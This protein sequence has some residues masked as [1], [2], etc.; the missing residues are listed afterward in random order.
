MLRIGE[1]V[2]LD[3]TTG[4][5]R[6]AS[7][8]RRRAVRTICVVVVGLLC[9]A[10]GGR[11]DARSSARSSMDPVV[12][13]IVEPGGFNVLHED[14][15]LKEGQERRLPRGMPR[16]VAVELSTGSWNQQKADLERG[17]LGHLEPGTL[18]SIT[19][20]RIIGIRISDAGN[21]TNILDNANHGTGTA[22]AA[23]GLVAGTDP[24][25]LL[26]LVPDTSKQSWEWLAAQDWIDIVSASYATLLSDDGCPSYA[27]VKKIASQGRLV[28]AAVGNGEQVGQFFDPSGVPEAYQ[29]GGVDGDGHTYLDPTGQTNPAATPNRPYETGDRFNLQAAAPDSLAGYRAFGGTSGATP[30]TAG[31]AAV[32]IRHARAILK[33]RT[34]TAR[35]LAKASSHVRKPARGPLADGDLTADELTDLLHHI[36]QPAEPESP[37]RYLIEGF[38]ALNDSSISLGRR[39]LQGR[40][41]EPARAAEEAMHEQVELLREMAMSRCS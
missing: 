5:G 14:F 38:G 10:S 7:P 2:T 31:R 25:A 23:A 26:V 16:T 24:E 15:K 39:V 18:Y 21:I 37:L 19:G 11:S 28:F 22:S 17:P 8:R 40:A 36:A 35:F 34:P 6:F 32:L 33:Q 12:I 9:V 41:E 20:T 1:R 29:V 30:S 13:A 3:A 27:S 4:S